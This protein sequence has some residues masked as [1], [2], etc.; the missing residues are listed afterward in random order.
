MD[1][2][3]PIETKISSP[4]MLSFEH[5]EDL[6]QMSRIE[7]YDNIRNLTFRFEN[8]NCFEILEER[9]HF[10]QM[11]DLKLAPE[12]FAGLEATI[13][14]CNEPITILRFL[15]KETLGVGLEFNFTPKESSAL[16]RFFTF[17]VR[18]R[19]IARKKL[20][21]LRETSQAIFIAKVYS[22][23][24]KFARECVCWR[25]LELFFPFYLDQI[26]EKYPMANFNRLINPQKKKKRGR[27][28]KNKS[29]KLFQSAPQTASLY[30]SREPYFPFQMPV[31]LQ[32]PQNL[33]YP[34][35]QEIYRDYQN[36]TQ[37]GAQYFFQNQL[38]PI[39]YAELGRDQAALENTLSKR[40]V[41]DPTQLE[42]STDQSI[43]LKW[44]DRIWLFLGFEGGRGVD[45]AA[46]DTKKAAR[47]GRRRTR[48]RTR[49]R[50]RTRKR[51]SRTTR[52]TS[53]LWRPGEMRIGF[54][55]CSK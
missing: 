23:E 48:G 34:T 54:W 2:S 25:M 5:L 18:P 26:L 15:F 27:G 29:Q 22:R 30:M 8:P 50:C 52:G 12:K 7:L 13:R 41:L 43:D 24:V 31:D 17:V 38:N 32:L 35:S 9:V 10:Y 39:S 46:G 44:F 37:N 4:T 1:T 51:G 49:T 14:K 28:R 53:R 40:G 20:N 47:R 55:K 16:F 3:K 42:K 21:K 36:Y 6:K 45:R 33:Y 11:D 19:I